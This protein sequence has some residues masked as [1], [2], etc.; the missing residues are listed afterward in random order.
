MSKELMEDKE[1]LCV[2]IKEAYARIVYTQ[3][4]HRKQS[5]SFQEK[6]VYKINTEQS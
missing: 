1:K 5:R 6:R 2:Q 3:T 4:A